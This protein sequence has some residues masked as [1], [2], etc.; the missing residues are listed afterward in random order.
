MGEV[1]NTYKMLVGKPEGRRS[2]G[3]YSRTWKDNI[4]MDLREIGWEVDCI[5]LDHIGTSG[6]IM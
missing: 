2:L 3:K 4:R 5:R 6:R 1:I